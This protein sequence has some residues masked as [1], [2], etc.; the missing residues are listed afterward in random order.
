M[1][2]WDLKNFSGTPN[3][4]AIPA[5]VGGRMPPFSDWKIYEI[6]GGLGHT[7]KQLSSC[8][9][10]ICFWAN[11]RHQRRVGIWRTL[12]GGQ[13][14]MRVIKVPGDAGLNPHSRQEL[15]RVWGR[16]HLQNVDTLIENC[17]G[18]EKHT[19]HSLTAK[20]A[21]ET[22]TRLQEKPHGRRPSVELD[23]L[24]PSDQPRG[25]TCWLPWP[26]LPESQRCRAPQRRLRRASG[27]VRNNSLH[28]AQQAASSALISSFGA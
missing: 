12:T 3:S 9:Y 13:L 16:G 17:W 22:R 26:N 19:S 21:V 5:E 15:Q 23:G 18:T 10:D 2:I 27:E 8:N 6:R 28:D 14:D 1:I 11:C 25:Q 4:M 7:Q 20:R 24:L